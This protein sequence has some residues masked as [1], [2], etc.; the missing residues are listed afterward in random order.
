MKIRLTKEQVK[1]CILGHAVADALGVPVEFRRRSTLDADPVTG[2]RAFGTYNKPAGT[3]SDDTSMTL[4]AL[5]AMTKGKI[6]HEEI[7]RN[8]ADWYRCGAFTPG[9]DCFDVGNTCSAAIYSF[10]AEG[11]SPLDC[12]RKGEMDNGNGSL[13]RIIPFVLFSLATDE[14]ETDFP[15]LWKTVSDGSALTHAHDRSGLGCEIYATALAFALENPSLESVE[16]GLKFHRNECGDRAEYE[17]YSRI[18]ADLLRGL[19]RSEIRGSGYVVSALEA[20]LY[21]LFTTSSYREC[22]LKA[23]NLGEDTDTTAA[24]AGGLAGA[25]YGTEGIPCEWL[26]TLIKRDYIEDM[27]DRFSQAVL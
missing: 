9:N 7:M 24:I 1:A 12:G 8:F 18:D 11:K 22:V 10:L 13:M 19:D 17:A 23:V 26:D 25:V 5:E 2:M 21:C 15:R 6:D 14:G 27:C 20:A 3:W 4:C 16:Q